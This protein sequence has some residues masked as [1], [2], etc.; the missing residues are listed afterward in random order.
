MENLETFKTYIKTLSNSE[1]PVYGAQ[2]ENQYK[3]ARTPETR[4]GYAIGM[5]EISIEIEMRKPVSGEI[6]ALSD[7]ELLAALGA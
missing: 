7:D 5:E 4:L 1:L 2:L 6:D 3:R